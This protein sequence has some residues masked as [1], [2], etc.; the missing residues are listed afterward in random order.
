MAG[1][2]ITQRPN[3]TKFTLIPILPSTSLDIP[4]KM[5]IITYAGKRNE[6]HP[7]QDVFKKR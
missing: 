4:K 3:R 2:N 1:F 7:W 6:I 5:D